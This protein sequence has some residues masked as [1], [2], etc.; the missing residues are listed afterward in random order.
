MKKNHQKIALFY[1]C[2][3]LFFCFCFCCIFFF[4]F[5][6]VFVFFFYIKKNPRYWTMNKAIFRCKGPLNGYSQS[7]IYA[8]KILRFFFLFFFFFFKRQSGVVIYFLHDII[9]LS[10]IRWLVRFPAGI[11]SHALFEYPKSGNYKTPHRL[12]M[13]LS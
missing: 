4:V 13:S 9:G 11:A 7:A 3:F 10:T 1:V 2:L 6:F 12:H 5:F 8:H